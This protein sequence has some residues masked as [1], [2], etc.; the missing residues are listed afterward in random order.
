MS[1]PDAPAAAPGDARPVVAL[2]GVEK[3]F[4]PLQVLQ[5]V[6]LEARAGEV[7]AIIGGSGS[8]KSTMLRCIPMLEVPE[9]GEVLVAGE[10]VRFRSRGAGTSL[11]RAPADA[12]QV[13]RLR[14]RVGFVF[15]QFNL[16]PPLTVQ[17]NV[18]E[19]PVHVQ[20]R[21][22]AEVQ[23]EALALLEKVGI[24][25]KRDRYPAELSGGQQQRAAIARALA[26]RPEALLI[27]EPEVYGLPGNPTNPWLA[28]AGDYARAS[29][30]G[31]LTIAALLATLLLGGR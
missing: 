22:R 13:N 10:A 24:A 19:A 11:A 31:L 9:A 8:G 3:R 30:V 4:G 17:G 6:S 15:Q 7:V 25:D 12:A 26:M 16:W 28:M 2:A 23:A 21:P 29:A 27:D 18:M 20:R 14:T 5:G 1:A